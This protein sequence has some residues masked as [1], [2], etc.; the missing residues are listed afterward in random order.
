MNMLLRGVMTWVS[1]PRLNSYLSMAL[2]TSNSS[3]KLG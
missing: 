3:V 2:A 1:V